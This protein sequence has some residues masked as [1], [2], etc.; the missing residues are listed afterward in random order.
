[1]HGFM[2]FYR[3]GAFNFCFSFHVEKCRAF[4]LFDLYSYGER[5]MFDSPYNGN[6]KW[7]TQLL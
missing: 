1:M 7:K 3:F 5:E 2:I 6:G 4:C